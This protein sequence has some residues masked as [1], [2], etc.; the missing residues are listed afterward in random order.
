M[1]RAA[2][3]VALRRSN[4]VAQACSP[5]RWVVTG[6]ADGEVEAVHQFIGDG[7][8]GGDAHRTL[9]DV[10]GGARVTVRSVAA[11]ALRGPGTSIHACRIRVREGGRVLYFPGPLIPHR[12]AAHAGGT[13][14]DVGDGAAALVAGVIVRGREGMCERD[15]WERLRFHLRL[16]VDGRLAF[17]EDTSIGA[18]AAGS[19]AGFAGAAAALT[20]YAVG[21]WA[22]AEASWWR[23]IPLP[24]GV[25]GGATELRAGGAAFR[26]LCATLGAAQQVCAT[27]ERAIRKGECEASRKA[28]TVNFFSHS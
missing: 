17:G 8:F 1:S 19:A 18:A 14:V 28:D 13:T 4:G 23:A 27:I 10:G 2:L 6:R 16:V 24:A 3:R 22:P 21:A 15:A 9:I 25:V 26:A 11:T 12:G 5:Q 20:V 7:I